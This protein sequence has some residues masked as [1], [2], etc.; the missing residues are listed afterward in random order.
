MR[1]RVF[2]SFVILMFSGLAARAA[3]L[4][5]SKVVLY[6]HG[7]VFFQRSGSVPPGDAAQL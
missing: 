2:A 6:K 3:D 5:V 7:I 4:T 1:I